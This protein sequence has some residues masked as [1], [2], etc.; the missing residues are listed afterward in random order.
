MF[1][2]RLFKSDK[3]MY[4][5]FDLISLIGASIFCLQC[6]MAG[7]LDTLGFCMETVILLFILLAPFKLLQFLRDIYV[8]F[9]V[10]IS[11]S[12]QSC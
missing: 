7:M 11:Y 6:S 2:I 8:V 12:V 4:V 9:I 3:A 1:S 5:N 10:H